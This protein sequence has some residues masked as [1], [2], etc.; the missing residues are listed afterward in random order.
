MAKFILNNKTDKQALL[1]WEELLQSVRKTT[2]AKQWQSFEEKAAFKK[3]IEKPGNQEAWFEYIFPNYYQSKPAAF[4][5]R[6][7]KRILGKR[8]YRQARR[9]AR[10]LA[11]SVRRM[12]EVFY[13]HFVEGYPLNM[14]MVSKTEDNAARLLDPYRANLEAN[15]RLI[16]LY[17][18]QVR[19]GKWGAYEF[20][21]RKNAS[22]RAVGAEQN[23]RG[24]RLEEL[25][26]SCIVF[27]DVDDDEVCRNPDRLQTRW[28]W[29]ERAVIPTIDVAGDY[30]IFFDN[31]PI[32]EDC[33]VNRFAGFCEDNEIVP[34]EYDDGS[35]SW[36]EKNSLEDIAL[37]KKKHER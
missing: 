22:F 7:T 5:I 31:N 35:S 28:E 2:V 12:M 13:K 20:V 15:Q 16:D 25:R 9:W 27:D 24:A 18:D 32:D 26:V 4:H 37:I 30:L 29:V 11:K 6:S 33:L 17:G 1:E 3:K 36:I 23:P 14:L 10:G 34:M 8:R 21:T 19:S